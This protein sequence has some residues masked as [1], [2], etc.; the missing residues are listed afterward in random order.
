MACSILSGLTALDVLEKH[1]IRAILGVPSYVP[2]YWMLKA[3]PEFL[4]IGRNGEQYRPGGMGGVN[5]L[6]LQY[7][8]YV[9]RFDEALARHYGADHR[10]LGWQIDNEI[11]IRGGPC[12][13]PEC[14]RAFQD[15]LRQKFGSIG[16]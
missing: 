11:G 14:V 10:V 15:R 5:L 6:D 7:R 1:G 9:R 3:D 2:L 13:N 12:Y 16:L 4:W 8:E